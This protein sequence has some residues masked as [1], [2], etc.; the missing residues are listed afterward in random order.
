[1]YRIDTLL[2][3]KEKLFHTNDLSLLWGITNKNTLYTTIK[4]YVQKGILIPIHKGFYSTI[5]L[6]QL[7]PFKLAVGYLHQYA[8]VSCETVL[9][10]EGIIFQKENYLT[11]ISG[12]SKKFMI[13]N[14]SYLVRQL[15][16]NYLY[17]DR[18]VDKV[19]TVMTASIERAVADLLYFN[20]NYY[21]DNKKK[22]DWKKVKEIQIAIGY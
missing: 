5:P 12:I 18:E 8:Y 19:D 14:H 10:R 17:H 11:L 21:F 15:S 6:D 9:I 20:P 4:R 13:S 1:M 2:K 7:N 22:I 3:L 16:N